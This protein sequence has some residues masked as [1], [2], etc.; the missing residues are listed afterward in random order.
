MFARCAAAPRRPATGFT[1]VMFVT[2]FADVPTV[3]VNILGAADRH[4]VFLYAPG[5]SANSPTVF[6]FRV[7]TTDFGGGQLNPFDFIAIGPR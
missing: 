7:L 4:F 1:D 2:P 3:T 6:G 5:T